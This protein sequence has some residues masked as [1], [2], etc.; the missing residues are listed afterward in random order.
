VNKGRAALAVD[1]FAQTVRVPN[2]RRAQLSFGAA[3]TAEWA[4]TVAVGTLAFE[5]GGAT[6]VGIVG[7]A[8]MLPAALL[9]PSA[10]VVV[11]RF[12]RERVLAGVGLIRTTSLAGAAAALGSLSSP[13]LAYA[14]VAIETVAHTLY[15]PAHSALLP[16]ICTTATQLTS[17]NVVR[18]LLDSASALIGP[19]L[20]AVLVGPIGIDGLLAVCAALALWSV[21]LILRVRYERAPRID[22]HVR[23][24]PVREAIEGVVYVGRNRDVR[25]LTVLAAL[26]TFTRG[27]FTVFAVVIAL[28][29]LGLHADGVGLLT[30]GFGAGAIAGSLGVSL[31]V[32]SSGFGRWLGISVALWGIPF[33]A[34]AAV[35]NLAVAIL[36]LAVVG[37]ANAVL[38]V[39]GFTLFQ[40]LVP[41]ELM[42]R[43]FTSI[44]SLMTLAIAVGSLATPGLIAVFGIR[45]ALVAAGLV[46]PVGALLA[47]PGLRRIDRQQQSVGDRVNLLQRVEML[48]PLPVATISQLA[49]KASVDLAPPGS[50]VIREGTTGDDFYVIARGQAE[51]LVNGNR[52]QVLGAAGCFGE[53]AALTGSRRTGTVRADSELKL[54]RFTREHFVR[55]V[56]NYAPSRAAATTLVEERLADAATSVMLGSPDPAD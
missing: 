48:R 47:V 45:G 35:S 8:R 31:L 38:D 40:W 50:D 7:L 5:H 17:A 33:V 36:L 41:D 6:A 52:L 23:A 15:R 18:G 26:Q 30:A 49:A 14:L 10:A 24:Q 19:L 3:W 11:D 39:S 20:A 1:A 55:A 29:L 34:L 54:L 44:E 43:V 27:C 28:Q 16:S 12:R 51:V 46:G 37:V 56:T 2:L 32:R 53:I 42:G 21:W 22:E 25:L 13:V 4:V 9:A